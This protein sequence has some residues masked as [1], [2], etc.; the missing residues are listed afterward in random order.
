[1]AS[2]AKMNLKQSYNDAPMTLYELI[3]AVEDRAQNNT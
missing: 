2:K 3:T 1:M